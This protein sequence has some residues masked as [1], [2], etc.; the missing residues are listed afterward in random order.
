MRLL[1]ATDDRSH[2]VSTAGIPQVTIDPKNE[3]ADH[4]PRIYVPSGDTLGQAY[5]RALASQMDGKLEVR[6]FGHGPTR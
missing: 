5:F 3:A 2:T 4:S 6:P 1:P